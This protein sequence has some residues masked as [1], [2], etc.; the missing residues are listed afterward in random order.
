[1]RAAL[2]LLLVAV[3]CG[4]ST[5]E[6]FYAYGYCWEPSPAAAECGEYCEWI[7]QPVADIQRTCG[8]YKI[9]CRLEFTC[10]IISQYSEADAAALM[11]YG[12]SHKDHE[13]MHLGHGEKA[14]G[15]NL[16]HPSI[17]DC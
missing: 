9:G 13:L 4:G 1:M 2:L 8:A 11:I 10:Q 16:R 6:T 14:K 15:R 3:A 12:Q 5:P 7:Q 17:N